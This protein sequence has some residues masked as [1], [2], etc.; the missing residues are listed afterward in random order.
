MRVQFLAAVVAVC[1]A[2]AARAQSGAVTTPLADLQ[3][4]T[5]V[6]VAGTIEPSTH[7]DE[8]R[9]TDATGSIH[10]Y[11]DP[12]RVPA[13]QDASVGWSRSMPEA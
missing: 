1:A 13:P 10:V 11:V 4:G 8:F 12:S 2:C 9:L 7:T 6:T 3:R 5:V